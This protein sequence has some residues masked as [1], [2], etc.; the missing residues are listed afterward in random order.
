MFI[1]LIHTMISDP[2]NINLNCKVL[3]P[4]EGEKNIIIAELKLQSSI[5][6]SKIQL[7]LPLHVKGLS[8]LYNLFLFISI[9][10]DFGTLLISK[11]II[12]VSFSINEI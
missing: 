11:L 10:F 5:V 6:G 12:Q 2:V 4:N 9:I 1:S 8:N 3:I 7:P